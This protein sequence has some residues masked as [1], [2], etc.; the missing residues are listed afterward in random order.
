[1]KK[2]Y[3]LFLK[4]EEGTHHSL[5]AVSDNERHSFQVQISNPVHEFP[6]IHGEDHTGLYKEFRI[7]RNQIKSYYFLVE[8]HGLIEGFNKKNLKG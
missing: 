8:Q 5:H 6:L 1:M 4:D 7:K 3:K 2:T